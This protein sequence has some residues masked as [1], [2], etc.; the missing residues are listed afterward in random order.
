MGRLPPS[1][2]KVCSSANHWDKECLD[3]AIYEAKQGKSA[4]QIKVDEEKDLESYYN[5]VYSVLVTEH[6]TS[7]NQSK[8]LERSDFDKAALESEGEPHLREHKSKVPVVPWKKQTVFMEEVEDSFWKEF[9]ALEKLEKHLLYQEGD[10]DDENLK[11]EALSSHKEDFHSS[12][13]RDDPLPATYDRKDF[14]QDDSS[15]PSTKPEEVKDPAKDPLSLPPP[16]KEHHFK[17][18]KRRS[19]PEGMSAV[20]VSVLSARGF[21]RS[22]KNMETDLRFDSCADITLILHE[23]YESLATKP[24]IKQGMR[25]HLWQLTD[26]D[27]KLKGF[28]HI[29]IFLATETGNILETEVEAYIVPNMTVPILLGEDYQQSY[30]V[31]VTRNVELGTHIG[32]GNHD[33]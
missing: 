10:E 25:M 7:E 3:Y 32:F 5:S 33:Y 17:M 15:I 4:Y 13:L 29:P 21:V 28:V 26:K 19:R 23:F 20:G 2:C 12:D 22:L 9:D 24:S 1:P 11:K 8:D 27:S 6:L 31:S 30:E 16:T 18:L 14:A